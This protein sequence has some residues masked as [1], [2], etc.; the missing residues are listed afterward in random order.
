MMKSSG[1]SNNN[2]SEKSIIDSD[3]FIFRPQALWENDEDEIIAEAYEEFLKFQPNST[4]KENE[5][6]ASSI[7]TAHIHHK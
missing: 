6:N 1:K 5:K 7:H 2:F 4:Q 3:Y